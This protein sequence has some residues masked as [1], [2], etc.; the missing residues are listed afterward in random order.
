MINYVFKEKYIVYENDGI[1]SVFSIKRQSYL[2]PFLKG[3]YI[4]FQMAGRAWFSHHLVTQYYLG[5]RD[6]N[7]CVNHKDG[8]K[9][10]NKI[11]NL[12]YVTWAENIKHSY[13][14]GLHIMA[15]DPTKSPTYKDGRCK[16]VKKYKFNWYLQ[17]RD[18]ILE[19][20]RNKTKNRN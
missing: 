8:N 18:R 13:R 2:M 1:V 10:N 9:L 16:D 11:E 12:E 7:L 4:V 20:L 5:K 15:K 3:G 19:K 14:M 6:A 17:N